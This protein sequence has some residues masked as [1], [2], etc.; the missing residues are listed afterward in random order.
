M[1]PPAVMT[2]LSRLFALEDDVYATGS[3]LDDAV[4]QLLADADHGSCLVCD[5]RTHQIVGGARCQDC[6]A[7]LLLGAEQAPWGAG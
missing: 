1:T 7:E 2:E 3:S 5:G 6:G 4:L